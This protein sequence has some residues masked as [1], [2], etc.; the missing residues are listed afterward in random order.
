VA[1]IKFAGDTILT[2]FGA[3][4][5]IMK[6]IDVLYDLGEHVCHGGGIFLLANINIRV[7]NIHVLRVPLELPHRFHD[8]GSGLLPLRATWAMQ[9]L[10]WV[11][12]ACAMTVKHNIQQ[13]VA[14]SSRLRKRTILVKLLALH[15]RPKYSFNGWF[16][17]SVIRVHK[18]HVDKIRQTVVTQ[19][20]HVQL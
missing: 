14:E 19:V 12:F 4:V 9:C 13:H 16:Q 18:L 8:A 6:N 10:R 15:R 17:E 3:R 7:E 2:E 1:Q 20:E 5:R 11:R